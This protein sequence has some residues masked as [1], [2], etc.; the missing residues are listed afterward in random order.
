MDETIDFM[1]YIVDVFVSDGFG[2]E[3]SQSSDDGIIVRV[4]VPEYPFHQVSRFFPF[5]C[6][7]SEAALIYWDLSNLI[8]RKERHAAKRMA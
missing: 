7:P 4:I 6:R 5:N 3:L 2:V 1:D 8:R